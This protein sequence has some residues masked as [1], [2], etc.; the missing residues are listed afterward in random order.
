M[1][2][3]IKKLLLIV[4]TLFAF[5]SYAGNEI[6]WPYSAQQP[7]T[8]ENSKGLWWVPTYEG[9][10]LYNVEVFDNEN[11]ESWMRVTEMDP[12][13]Y[14]VLSSGEGTYCNKDEEDGGR[15]GRYVYMFPHA[16]HPELSSYP[17]H[18][19]EV[20]TEW[21]VALGTSIYK[22]NQNPEHALGYKEREEP[23]NCDYPSHSS[24]LVCEK[25]EWKSIAE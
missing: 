17:L 6:P 23:L 2:I 19:A 12:W 4:L 10:V 15:S 11:G 5:Q 14:E 9:S 13:T 3:A 7:M 24:D 21:G 16:K 8:E 20:A 18:L 1:G 22:D 25:P